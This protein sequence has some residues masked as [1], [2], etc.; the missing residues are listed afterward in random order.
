MPSTDPIGAAFHHAIQDGVFPGAVL[1]VRFQGRMVYQCGFGHVGRA[2]ADVPVSLETVYDLASLTKVLATTSAILLL[3]QQGHLQLEDPIANILRECQGATIG[4]AQIQHLLS[5]SSGLPSWKPFYKAI[6][7]QDE[8]TPGFLGSERAKEVILHAIT[9]EK[10]I[11][12]IGARAEYSDLGFML[13]GFLVERISSLPL[14]EFCQQFLCSE[15]AI[16][17]DF[18]PTSSSF[19]EGT[20]LRDWLLVAPTEYDAWRGRVLQG[21]VHDENAYALGGVAGH[22]GLFG[23]A[24]GVLA[25]SGYWLNSYKERDSIFSSEL[26]KKFVAKHSQVS[27]SSWALGWDTPSDPSSSGQYFSPHSFGHLGFTGTSLWI[28]PDKELEVVLLSNR[29]YFGRENMKIRAFRKIIHDL[30][31]KEVVE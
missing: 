23:S 29:V 26:T 1:A 4:Q 18:I 3:V 30:I 31:W 15:E 5:H 16:P 17:L 11:A 24:A 28:D 22:A 20:S 8:V 2:P 19:T 27:G 7:E 9:Q 6:G 25:I 10:L 13:L 14:S 21:E 12:T